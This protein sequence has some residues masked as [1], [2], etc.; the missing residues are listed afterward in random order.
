MLNSADA[1]ID[2]SDAIPRSLFRAVHPDIVNAVSPELKTRAERLVS[3]LSQAKEGKKQGTSKWPNGTFTDAENVRFIRRMGEIFTE[4]SRDTHIGNPDEFVDNLSAFIKDGTLPSNEWEMEVSTRKDT[5]AGPSM[6]P[7]YEAARAEQK[8]WR[9]KCKPFVE[10]LKREYDFKINLGDESLDGERM[11][12][13]LHSMSESIAKLPEDV[14]NIV[15]GTSVEFVR[16]PMSPFGSLFPFG[17]SIQLNMKIPNFFQQIHLGASIGGA[18]L[19]LHR[20][21]EKYA[22]KVNSANSLPTEN[23]FFWIQDITATLQ[24]EFG[25]AVDVGKYDELAESKIWQLLHIQETLDGLGKLDRR[26]IERA[27]GI[28]IK[29]DSVPDQRGSVRFLVTYPWPGMR[30]SSAYDMRQRI[31][32]AADDPNFFGT[33]RRA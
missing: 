22:N 29:F 1:G 14:R 33:R 32:A 31:K 21:Q 18:A 30:D 15:R 28:T 7:E 24:S 19:A 3:I 16:D 25:V 26:Y 13:E 5:Q 8:E 27:K 4:A 11:L 17:N 2:S 6:G 10:A 23:T 20:L 9:N 12:F